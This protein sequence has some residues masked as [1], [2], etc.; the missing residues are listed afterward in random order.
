MNLIRSNS[1]IFSSSGS[2]NLF[3]ND[4]ILAL[5]E[6][7]SSSKEYSGT[8]LKTGAK[9]KPDFLLVE[10]RQ[11]RSTVIMLLKKH[12]NLSQTDPQEVMFL[13]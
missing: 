2:F 4:F 8:F 3:K 10:A 13:L 6:I 11:S 12:L 5:T 1:I 7:P 9:I